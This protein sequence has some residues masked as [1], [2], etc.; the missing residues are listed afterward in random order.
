MKLNEEQIKEL[1]KHNWDV[2]PD[3]AYIDLYR[4]LFNK[5]NDWE[6]LCEQL[7]VPKDYDCVTILYMA[8]KLPKRII[9]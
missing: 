1:E 3:C 9:L 5:N 4:Y 7:N 2:M 6:Q 8:T